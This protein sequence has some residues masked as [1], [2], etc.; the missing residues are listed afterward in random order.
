MFAFCANQPAYSLAISYA[1]LEQCGEIIMLVLVQQVGIIG[2]DVFDL[3]SQTPIN[4]GDVVGGAVK[5][6]M[7]LA[8]GNHV[9]WPLVVVD[10]LAR[11]T[12]HCARHLNSYTL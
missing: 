11:S 1:G 6:T 5:A 9:C 12:Q 4:G 2:S 8:I 7:S 10:M 3:V